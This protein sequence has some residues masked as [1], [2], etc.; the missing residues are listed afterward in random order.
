MS[1]H[2]VYAAP[3]QPEPHR[4]EPPMTPDPILRVHGPDGAPYP[5][6]PE[7][8]APPGSVWLCDCGRYWTATAERWRPSRRREL[9]RLDLR[10]PG[11]VQVVT[12]DVKPV[13]CPLDDEH[14]PRDFDG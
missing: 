12:A 6:M 8:L 3:E 14:R 10:N 4:C 2:L 5:F 11:L 9:R 7:P 13:P 1:G